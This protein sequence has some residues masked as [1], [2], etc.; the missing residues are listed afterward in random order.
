MTVHRRQRLHM[1]AAL[2]AIIVL[3]GAMIVGL[4]VMGEWRVWRFIT[5]FI[6]QLDAALLM[7]WVICTSIGALRARDGV[8]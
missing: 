6:V 7:G 1:I 3:H 8:A 4:A 2:V 5:N